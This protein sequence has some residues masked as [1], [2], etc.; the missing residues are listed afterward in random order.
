[1]REYQNKGYALNWSEEVFGIGKI[2]N[3]VPFEILFCKK[4]LP[5]TNHTEFRRERVIKKRQ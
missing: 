2:L 3:T 4:E 5:K 1:M